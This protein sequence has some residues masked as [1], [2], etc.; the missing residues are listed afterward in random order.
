M[1]NGPATPEVKLPEDLAVCTFST[2]AVKN[3]VLA[4]EHRLDVS[5]ES[6]RR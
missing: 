6:V 5:R 2:A 4:E 3:L 1:A